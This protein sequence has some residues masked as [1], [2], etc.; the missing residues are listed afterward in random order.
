MH[1]SNRL[2]SLTAGGPAVA[3]AVLA[4]A[5]LIIAC[6]AESAASV[7]AVVRDSAGIRIVEN[8]APQW[9]PE[10][11]WDVADA[12]SLDIGVFEG[13]PEYQ[14]FRV[15][16]AVRLDD[17]RIVVA[18]SGTHQLRY[19]GP[20]G[21]F[22]RA[23]GSEGG[24]PGEFS[25]LSGLRRGAGDSIITYDFS[26]R[27]ISVFDPAG[28]FTR[29]FSIEANQGF[30]VLREVLSDGTFI[31]SSQTFSPRT[32]GGR[33]RDTATWLR[34][35][36]DGTVLDTLHRFPDME[37]YMETGGSGTE[38]RVMITGVPF[39][40]ETESA[41]RG[42]HLLVGTGEAFEI[43]EYDGSGRL[44]GMIRR[45][46]RPVPL[47]KA[48]ID[49]YV[50][51]DIENTDEEN[52]ASARK[53]W[54]GFPFPETLMPFSTFRTDPEGNLWIEVFRDAAAETES[55]YDRASYVAEWHVF[56]PDGRWLGVVET[57]AGFRLTDIGS[58][59]VLGT[60]RDDLDVEHVRMFDL[61]KS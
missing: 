21:T 17:G 38:R 9:G 8:S 27:R 10:D 5:P 46:G 47:T 48:D 28:E 22:Q 16:G 11:A 50:Q 19:F 13:E 42:T 56:D 52:R 18:N 4:V 12:P 54:E 45:L 58:D 6:G 31:V 32:G 41:A 43:R 33:F 35:D 7:S 3:L 15:T 29:S 24:G 53:T 40:R 44:V 1:G 23:S 55:R 34:Y 37:M 57:P 36:A 26:N 51:T 2:N 49:H 59:Y 60:W 20:D 14:L 61:V 39:G 30:A 25:R